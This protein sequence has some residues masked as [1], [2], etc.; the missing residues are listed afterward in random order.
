LIT[1]IFRAAGRLA[2]FFAGVR[3][4]LLAGLPPAGFRV[5]DLAA[6]FR[7]AEVAAFRVA[8]L[9]AGFRVAEV[10]DFRAAVFPDAAL[11]ARFLAAVFPDAAFLA[12]AFPPVAFPAAGFLTADFRAAVFL[13]AAFPA[14]DAD[15][16]ALLALLFAALLA[17][18]FE[19]GALF[20]SGFRATLFRAPADFAPVE[21]FFFTVLPDADFAGEI[22][23]ALPLLLLVLEEAGLLPAPVFFFLALFLLPLALLFLGIFASLLI[24]VHSISAFRFMW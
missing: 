18:L 14:P 9:A 7:V 6:D 11:A 19:E 16:R 13:V 3:E 24:L 21:P 20:F 12:V 5:A 10:A 2:V 1:P 17:R 15:R 8:D 23:F 4:E 22:F